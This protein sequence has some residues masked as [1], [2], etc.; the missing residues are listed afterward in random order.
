MHWSLYYAPVP[1]TGETDRGSDGE[2]QQNL[3]TLDLNDLKYSLCAVIN[4]ID[5]LLCSLCL[6]HLLST[7][8]AELDEMFWNSS[9]RSLV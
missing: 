6:P 1:L 9:F 2:M 5:L 3:S 4:D 7:S 8:Q